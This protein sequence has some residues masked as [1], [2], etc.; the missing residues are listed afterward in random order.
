MVDSYYLTVPVIYA[1][2]T[3]AVNPL[4]ALQNLHARPLDLPPRVDSTQL[5]YSLIVHPS[6]SPLEDP[7]YVFTY[8]KQR[9]R[10]LKRIDPCP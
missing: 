5:R 7:M 4:Q 2:S 1:V 9:N 8:V 10:R 6:N 3:M